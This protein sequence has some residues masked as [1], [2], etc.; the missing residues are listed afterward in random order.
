MIKILSY[1]SGNVKAIGNIFKQLSIPCEVATSRESLHGASHLILPGVGAFDQTMQ[2]LES[3]GMLDEL[4]RLVLDEKVPVLG[5][6]V[7]MQ[8]MSE[9][10]EEGRRGGLGWIKGHVRKIDTSSLTSKPLL[11]HMGWNEIEAQT[12]HPIL[13]QIEFQKGFYFLHS[14][15]FVCEQSDN[16]L[17]NCL[18]GSKITC[19]IHSENIF[20]FQFHP[21][22]SHQNGIRVFRNFAEISSNR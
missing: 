1:G 21:E 15:H 14:Y 2:L 22:K 20:G 12:S 10:S 9:T 3:S 5:V 4:N 8:I 11:P 13:D 6:C 17:A 18:Y 16:V 7:G 19:A